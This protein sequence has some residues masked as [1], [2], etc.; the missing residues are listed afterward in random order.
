MKKEINRR[1]MI[2]G[3]AALAALGG[4]AVCTRTKRMADTTRT[5]G[6][7]IPAFDPKRDLAD[8]GHPMTAYGEIKGVKLSRLIQGGNMI[9]GWAH[10]RDMR[11]YDKLVK[12]YFTDERVFRNFR[13]AEAC[14]VN[15]ILTNPALMRVI[16][17]YWREEEAGSSSSPTAATRAA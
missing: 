2:F 15:T 4:A 16:N 9:G 14:G 11:F 12:A 6:P 13:I 10:C 3:G 5:T 17:R 1:E 8:L 7:E